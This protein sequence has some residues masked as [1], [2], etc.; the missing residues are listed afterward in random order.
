MNEFARHHRLTERLISYWNEIRGERIMPLESDI[1]MDALKEEWPHCFLVSV[2]PDKFAYTYLGP[3]L[4]EAYGDDFTGREITETLLF[5]HPKPLFAQLQ[6]AAQESKPR[7]NQGEFVN[8]QGMH[9]K[10]RTCI[11]PLGA[12]GHSSVAFLL[13]GMNWKA[14]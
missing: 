14:Y 5:P 8:A 3:Q 12:H 7:E 11:L 10:Y 1:N 9:I 13:G 4:V 2:H 6:Q